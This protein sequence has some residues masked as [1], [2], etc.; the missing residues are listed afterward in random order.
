[1]DPLAQG[2]IDHDRASLARAITL[3]ESTRPDHRERATAILE[4]IRPL[5]RSAK[6]I[7][8]SGTPGVGKST[9][10]EAVGSHVIDAGHRLAVLA[11]DPTSASTGGSILGDKT[12][13]A[14]LARSHEAFI[15]PSPTSGVLGGVAARTAEVVS[16]CEAAG[17]DTVFVE[18]VGVG[19]SET[20]V[21]D[22][23]DIFV[24]LVSPGGGDDL[25]G[26]K[27]GVMELT[28][29]LVVNKADGQFADA[30]KRTAQEYAAALH[31]V[32]PKR[33]DV[34]AEVL[35]SS[36]LDPAAVT[37]VWEAICRHHAVLAEKGHI[38]RLRQAQRQLALEKEIDRLS[39]ALLADDAPLSALRRELDESTRAGLISPS[40]AA[41]D[42]RTALHQRLTPDTP[43]P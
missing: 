8:I 5:G 25:Q 13:M 1:M 20:M 34:P 40:R 2:I 3:V 31:M 9:F 16:L 42:Y 37:A 29:L 43:A 23:T 36:S 33:A 39:L 12:R 15:R 26:I 4:S 6:R 19:Q 18:T 27:R 10:I 21:A 22:M 32:R 28:D 35:T 24:L 17:F 7:G 30:A 11:I 38:E 41:L 14:N